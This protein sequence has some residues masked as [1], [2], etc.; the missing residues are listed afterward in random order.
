MPTIYVRNVPKELYLT[1]Q[2]LAEQDEQSISA[3]VIALLQRAAESEHRKRKRLQ[4]M[5]RIESRYSQFRPPDDG[6]DTLA[7]LREDR[8]R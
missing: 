4:A 8:D 3:E 7:L 6:K 1:V 5:A 2:E